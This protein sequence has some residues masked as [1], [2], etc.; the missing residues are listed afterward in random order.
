MSTIDPVTAAVAALTAAGVTAYDTE[1]EGVPPTRYAVVFGPA[2]LD[3][4]ATLDGV[5]RDQR[6]YLRV[7][8]V[9]TGPAQA[10]RVQHDVAA[11]LDG[12]ALDVTGYRASLR[13]IATSPVTTAPETTLTKT[14]H[15]AYATDTYKYEATP[16]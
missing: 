5:A 12:A 7:M 8:C 6:D 13:R 16:A 3:V 14:A 4:A 15:P 1:E 11:A 9:G 10:R 2:P